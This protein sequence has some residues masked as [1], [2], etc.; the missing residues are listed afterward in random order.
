MRL[1]RCRLSTINL[2]AL[3]CPAPDHPHL[4]AA[5]L[6]E[7]VLALS[8]VLLS[9]STLPTEFHTRECVHRLSRARFASSRGSKPF[10]NP[11]RQ[12]HLSLGLHCWQQAELLLRWR[13]DHL[14]KQRLD[15]LLCS[16]L[17]VTVRA[18][19]LPGR[20]SQD[21]LAYLRHLAHPNSLLLHPGKL[22]V[23]ALH[24]EQN[25]LSQLCERKMVY[26]LRL[27]LQCLTPLA[28]EVSSNSPSFGNAYQST[29]PKFSADPAP[30]G[31]RS[32]QAPLDLESYLGFLVTTVSSCLASYCS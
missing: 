8:L 23:R 17:R 1:L 31:A 10:H 24:E 14:P 19:C 21:V 13:T 26:F 3:T 7:R 20:R 9:P 22:Q 16:G 18:S 27:H 12:V 4:A 2:H 29:P 6:R 32:R 11:S 30:T 5:P 25:C 28:L 15:H